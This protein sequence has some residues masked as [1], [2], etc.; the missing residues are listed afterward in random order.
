MEVPSGRVFDG[1]DL[2]MVKFSARYGF[3]SWS[4][5]PVTFRSGMESRV[6]VGGREDFTDHPDLAWVVG[7]RIMTCVLQDAEARGDRKQQCLIGIPTAGTAFAQAAAMV[8]FAWERVLYWK[9]SVDELRIIHRIMREALKTHGVHPDWVNGK[10]QPDLHTYWMVDNTV[11]DGGTKVEAREHLLQ[12]NYPVQ[13][14][15]TLVVVDRQQGG[16]KRMEKAGFS[17]IVVAY[18]LLDLTYAF[19]ELGLWPK[20]AVQAVEEEIKAHQLVS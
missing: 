12:S 15:R 11:T 3:I 8:N 19:R 17:N 6:T 4:D 14:M 5:Q 10:P 1:V 18:Y 20:D 13:E 7:R 16:I 2:N 9:D